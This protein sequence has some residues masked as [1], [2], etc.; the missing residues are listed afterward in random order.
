MQSKILESIGIDPAYILIFMFLILI[1]LCV[2]LVSLNMKYNRLKRSYS[3]FMRG[4]DGKTLEDNIRRHLEKME[5]IEELSE[6]N[7]IELDSLKKSISSS[8]QKTGL[9]QYDAFHEMGGKLSFAFTI[10][11]GED[12][13]WIL[14]AMH[15][16]DGCYIYIK[17]IVNG[18]CHTQLAEE[19]AESLERAMFSDSQELAGIE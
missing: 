17:E 13:G 7:Q 2:F 1:V 18:E 3:R 12:N 9:V 10:L 8:I 5:N 16:R 6:Q 15:N 11:D 19:E 14:N 4:S